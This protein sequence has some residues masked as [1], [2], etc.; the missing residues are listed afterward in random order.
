M[1]AAIGFGARLRQ[2]RLAAGL[3]QEV[4]AERAGVS[5]KAISDLERGP[6]RSPRL[7]TVALLADALGL[8]A[9]ER[10]RFLAAARPAAIPP[11]ETT[12]T[13]VD[14]APPRALP[15]PL[16][17]LIGRDGVT[18]AVA[19]LLRRNETQLLTLTGPGG[20]GK[21]RVAIAVAT[22]VSDDFADGAVFV[23]LAP[24]R[25]P[26][27]VLP[28]IAQRLGLDER[29]AT[30]LAERLTVYLRGKR[31]LLLLDNCEHLIAARDGLRALLEACPR[32]AVLATSRVALRVRGEREY[33][34]APL[35]LPDE[36]DAPEALALAPAVTL[37]LERSRAVGAEP[38]LNSTNILAVAA[39]CRRLDG[40]PLA[41]ELAAAWSR[42]LPPPALLARLERRLPLLVDG[43][44]D[45]PARQRTMRGAIAWSYDLL[46]AAEQRLFRQFA[47]F[48]GD[49]TVTAAEAVC[50]GAGD[51]PPVFAGLA[52]LVEKSLLR[53]L[54]DTQAGGAEPRLIMLETLR[55][56]GLEQLAE[57][58][59]EHQARERHRAHYLAL[60]EGSSARVERARC[61]GLGRAARS[62]AR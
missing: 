13:S 39:I 11:A 18:G 60:A 36:G 58:G 44:T 3:T 38:P 7:D 14:A 31:F 5:T 22:R 2:L 24:L 41:I 56:F 43:A 26:A 27:L 52:A 34:I 25:D 8:A 20:V 48:A 55:E 45:L 47:V 61:R 50:A 30:P 40:L 49:C 4:L 10:A 42:L 16:T 6:S 59:E 37:F 57:R 12:A 23:D 17:P 62:R 29:D 33:R 53:R 32:L 28:T 46:D 51:D 35:E 21:T 54:D 9:A 1:T 15:R 19:A